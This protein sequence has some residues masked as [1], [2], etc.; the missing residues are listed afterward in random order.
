MTIENV[1]NN[2]ILFQEDISIIVKIK[3]IKPTKTYKPNADTER[4][5]KEIIVSD[6]K[7]EYT[8][9]LY[10]YD[11][12]IS[13]IKLLKKDDYIAIYNPQINDKNNKR[14]LNYSLNTIFIK[15]EMDEKKNTIP[16]KLSSQSKSCNIPKD[17]NGVLDFSQFQ[18]RLYLCDIREN[19]KNV[20]VFSRIVYIGNNSP[21]IINNEM[22]NRIGIK[23]EDSTG[24]KDVTLWDNLALQILK[25]KVGYYVFIENLMTTTYVDNKYYING[26][27]ENGCKI[28]NVNCL[29]SMISSPSFRQINYLSELKHE[30]NVFF[31]CNAVIIGWEPSYNGELYYF[32]HSN[33]EKYLSENSVNSFCHYCASPINEDI[34]TVYGINWIIDDGTT[35]LTVNADSS[36]SS[37][38]IG[39][40]I[41]IFK[42]QN[43]DIQNNILNDIIGKEFIFGICTLY[44]YNI[45]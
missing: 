14:I 6:P 41:N 43:H 22:R 7:S 2:D 15:I 16:L 13:F 17:D 23:I 37:E 19:T 31:Y 8:M 33:C 24:I 27:E 12:E 26:I 35:I 44:S 9:S 30:D 34:V 10:L 32:A 36:I 40:S 25:Y 28:Y 3:E 39:V 45:T 18:G 5:Q 4:Q 29:K 42:N 1:L 11:E 21:I 20:S 38:I